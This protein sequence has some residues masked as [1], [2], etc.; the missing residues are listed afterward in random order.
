LKSKYLYLSVNL[1][2][3][4]LP[5]IFSFY[6]KANFSK[7]WR[8]VL[9]AIAISG[10][11]FIIWDA[12]FT[13]LGVW[14]FNP[15]YITGV[16]LIGL[17]IEEI[18]F[19]F[20]IPY[21]CIFT[22]FALNYLI[23]KDHLFPHQELITSILIFL[24]LVLGGYFMS[25]LYTGVT[26]MITGLFLALIMLKLRTR[27]MG[28]FYFAFIV[29]LLP[30]LIVNGILTGSFIEEPVVWYNNE[31]NLGIRLGTI[32]VEDV[33]YGMLMLLLPITIAEKWEEYDYYKK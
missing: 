29:I 28:R 5:F 17:P 33:V 13:E 22:Y 19:F 23:E 20:C 10:L 21:A 31:E 7:K 25:N 26:F 16:Y 24:L 8:Y 1:L 12:I 9:P 4:A 2:S 14:G 27:F 18:L 15:K 6:P 30:F 11:F 32:P 3:F